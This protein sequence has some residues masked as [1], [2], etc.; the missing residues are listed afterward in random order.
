MT[1][2]AFIK[3]HRQIVGYLA[4]QKNV[5]AVRESRVWDREPESYGPLGIVEFEMR[6]H[7]APTWL[8]EIR[9][10]TG[11]A[12]KISDVKP[13]NARRYEIRVERAAG[14]VWTTDRPGLAGPAITLP[15]VIPPPAG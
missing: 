3:V 12:Y 9:E 13:L 10:H 11:P 1:D 8:D 2:Q 7:S 14:G 6:A 4:E 5:T 15:A